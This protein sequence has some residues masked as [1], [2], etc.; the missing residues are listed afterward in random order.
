MVREIRDGST[1]PKHAAH[2]NCIGSTAD[3]AWTWADPVGNSES[4]KN[5]ATSSSV[6]T[7]CVHRGCGKS[8]ELRRLRDDLNAPDAYYVVFTDATQELDIHY[9]RHQ[10]ILLHLASKLMER[11]GDLRARAIALSKI[12]DILAE[13]GELDEALRIYEGDVLPAP[14]TINNE[15]DIDWA[16][17]RIETLRSTQARPAGRKPARR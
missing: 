8:T 15:K 16:R 5:E 13:R 1:P 4:R 9:P 2:I 12:A 3:F 7:F 14:H 6:D 11:L 10:D 17:E